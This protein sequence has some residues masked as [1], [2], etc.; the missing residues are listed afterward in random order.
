M[1]KLLVIGM[2]VGLS[3]GASLKK[4]EQAINERLQIRSAIVAERMLNTKVESE[5]IILIEELQKELKQAK[6]D[7]QKELLIKTE[8]E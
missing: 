1:K 3:F 5:L 7:L 2:V 4:A 6:D 8:V